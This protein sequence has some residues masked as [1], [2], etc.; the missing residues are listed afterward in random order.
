[1]QVLALVHEHVLVRGRAL[2][3]D[4]SG[5]V[6]DLQMGPLPVDAQHPEHVGDRRPRGL[7]LARRDPAPPTVPDSGQVLLLGVQ[8]LGQDHLLPLAL[9]ER[10]GEL[11]AVVLPGP[12]EPALQI[13]VVD[14]RQG[15]PASRGHDLVRHAVHVGDPDPRAGLGTAD[16]LVELLFQAVGEAAVEGRQQHAAAGVLGEAGRAVNHGH[17]LARAGTARDQR[18]SAV[19]LAVGHGAL[20][21]VQEDPPPRERRLQH[22]AQLFRPGHLHEPVRCA[23][24]GRPDVL[25]VHCVR[26]FVGEQLGADLPPHLLLVVARGEPG[27]HAV[28]R[29]RE[30]LL[31]RVQ[32]LQRGHRADHGQHVVVDAQLPE[33]RVLELVEQA[34]LRFGPLGRRRPGAV[35][36]RLV[37]RLQDAEHAVDGEPL[38]RRVLVGL[39]VRQHGDQHVVVAPVRGQNDPAVVVVDP[40]RADLRVLRALELFQVLAR[41]AGAELHDGGVHVPLHPLVQL[42]IVLQDFVGQGQIRHATS[43]ISDQRR[44]LIAS[45]RGST[46]SLS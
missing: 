8:L 2:G 4:P 43:R 36:R 32:L 20:P 6:G 3:A 30:Q 13:R 25:R 22:L 44:S 10:P 31:E 1:M 5:L 37:A 21:G 38:A 17:G 14:H 23:G 29:R 19:G 18:G 33:L 16:E 40:D 11:A 27:Q 15:F 41:M 7:T 42:V 28:L 24:H 9:E 26:S 34:G 45:T 39:V 12:G 46:L 35:Q